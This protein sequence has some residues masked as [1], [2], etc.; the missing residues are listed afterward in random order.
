LRA[1]TTG[2]AIVIVSVPEGLPL[3]VSLAMAF[4]VDSMKKDNLLVKK[5]ASIETLGYIKDICTGKTA[6]LTEN[7]M[8]VIKFCTGEQEKTS[9]HEVDERVRDIMIDTIIKNCDARVEMSEEATYEPVGNGTE[10]AML[11]F[12]QENEIQVHELLAKRQRESEHECSIPFSPYRKRQTTVFRP[13]KGCDKVRVVVKGAPEI[14]L[15]MCT[16]MLD[17]T[18]EEQ[19]MDDDKR[20]YVLNKCILEK[21]AKSH[22]YRTFAYAYKDIDSNQWEHLQGQHENF[23]K[24]SDREVVE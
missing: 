9:L 22:G 13:Y 1:F 6:T 12:L 21:F 17:S 18:G 8:K 5:M 2:V 3:A 4:S 19:E 10:V 14:V 23:I 20:D 15:K 16:K 24:E 11:K 7:K